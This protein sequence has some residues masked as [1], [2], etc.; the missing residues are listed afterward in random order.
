MYGEYLAETRAENTKTIIQE[1]FKESNRMSKALKTRLESDA[2]SNQM[3]RRN[4]QPSLEVVQKF[5]ADNKIRN[6]RAIAKCKDL[7]NLL[8]IKM[9]IMIDLLC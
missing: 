4:A 3:N 7:E 1:Y 2:Q 5:N 6:L 9:I 8:R